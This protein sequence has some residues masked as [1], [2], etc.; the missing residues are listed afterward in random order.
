MD[1]KNVRSDFLLALWIALLLYL[2]GMTYLIADI[3][4][5]LGR[6]E[7]MAIHGF[8]LEEGGHSWHE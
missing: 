8:N 5:R 7:H 2:I 6:L 4:H 1:F 3:E